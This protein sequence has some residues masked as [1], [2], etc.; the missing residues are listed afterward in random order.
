MNAADVASAMVI[1]NGYGDAPRSCAT[2]NAIG[3]MSTAVAVFE[4]K[5]P[6]IEVSANNAVKSRRGSAWPKMSSP[7]AGELH[8]AGFLKCGRKRHHAN[9]EDQVSATGSICRRCSA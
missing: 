1:I 8:A 5:R 7:C 6:M 2:V 9:D 3:A 4:T